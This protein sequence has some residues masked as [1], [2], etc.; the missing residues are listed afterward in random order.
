MMDENKITFIIDE[1]KNR[2]TFHDIYMS[3]EQI[4][5]LKSC[6]RQFDNIDYDKAT[7]PLCDAIFEKLSS[8]G[9][10]EIPARRCSWK[11]SD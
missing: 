6:I 4:E 11:W 3:G 1:T 9:I 10:S 2:L 7:N 5:E 8:F